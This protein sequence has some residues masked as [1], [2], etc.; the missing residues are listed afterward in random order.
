MINPYINDTKFY[1]NYS[2]PTQSFS[3][4]PESSYFNHDISNLCDQFNDLNL[5]FPLQQSNRISYRNHYHKFGDIPDK[6][7]M[8]HLC[9]KKDHFIQDCP[10]VKCY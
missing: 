8:C 2:N 3:L 7:Y 4:L 9:F 6:N 10:K 1:Q 5:H